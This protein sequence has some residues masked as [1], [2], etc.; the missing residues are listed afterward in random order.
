VPAAPG[1]I[2]ICEICFQSLLRQDRFRSLCHVGHH[3][4]AIN[5]LLP[6][7]LCR[8]L[9][10][11]LVQLSRDPHIWCMLL[12]SMQSTRQHRC[13]MPLSR[14][15]RRHILPLRLI[16]LH[17]FQCTLILLLIQLPPLVLLFQVFLLLWLLNKILEHIH[18]VLASRIIFGN[19]KLI[20]MVVSPIRFLGFLL[21]NHHHMLLP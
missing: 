1:N 3:W 10:A 13:A 4:E 8:I 6:R 5:W 2:T 12:I 16:P 9:L 19:Q 14:S 20:L 15:P 21:L 17:Q 18:M 7:D 11:R